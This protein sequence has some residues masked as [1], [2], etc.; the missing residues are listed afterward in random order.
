MHIKTRFQAI[1]IRQV[2]RIFT[3]LSRHPQ[4]G[5]M[6]R[7]LQGIHGFHHLDA[8]GRIGRHLG[9]GNTG[10]FHP[11]A[12]AA[13]DACSPRRSSRIPAS[14]IQPTEKTK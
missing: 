11:A 6:S 1:E 9:R 7:L 2:S 5:F 8:V 10:N 13:N 14:T 3:A 4:A 12:S